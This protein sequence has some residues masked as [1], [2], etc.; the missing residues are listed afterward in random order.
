MRD[1]DLSLQEKIGVRVGHT[2]TTDAFKA[3]NAHYFRRINDISEVV[4]FAELP[5]YEITS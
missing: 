3:R 4:S 5:A 2:S 1:G